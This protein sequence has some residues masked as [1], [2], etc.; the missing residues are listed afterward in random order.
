MDMQEIDR[1]RA[2]AGLTQ[3]ALCALAGVHPT[4]YSALMRPG[5]GRM[6][7]SRTLKKLADALERAPR[8]E[9]AE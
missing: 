2:S 4:T 8:P 5:S 7:N 1:G 6:A 3:K 9:A